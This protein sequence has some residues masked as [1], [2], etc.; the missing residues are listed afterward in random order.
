MSEL[1][2]PS[3]SYYP[4]APAYPGTAYRPSIGYQPPMAGPRQY[5]LPSLP[6]YRPLP[7]GP[8]Y[9]SGPQ[10]APGPMQALWNRLPYGVRNTAYNMGRGAYDAAN[11]LM[12]YAHKNPGKAAAMVGGLS[13]LTAMCPYCG[14]AAGGAAAMKMVG[15]YFRR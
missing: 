9:A 2:F 14:A 4:Q 1:V 7:G 5:G 11:S 8:S 13:V 10:Y 6:A 12:D 3:T 15:N